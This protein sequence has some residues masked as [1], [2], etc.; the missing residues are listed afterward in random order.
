MTLRAT[1]R[2]KGFRRFERWMIGVVFA[3][4]AFVLEKVVMRSV[5]KKGEP[6]VA[7]DEVTTVVAK[8]GEVD[9]DI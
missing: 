2:P 3:V 1:A 7:P 5:R 9:V 4:M 8:G 6:P